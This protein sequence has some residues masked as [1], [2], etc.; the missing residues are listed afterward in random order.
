MN[1]A[2]ALADGGSLRAL[3]SSLLRDDLVVFPVR[4]HSPACALHLL[5]LIRDRRPSAVLIEGPRSFN[6][7]INLLTDE[8]ARMPLAI[9]TY[10]VERASGDADGARHAAYY[11]F[12]D[13]SPELVALR[14]AAGLGV[15]ARFIDLDYS[16]QC[17]VESGPPA[18]DAVSL[19]AE[20]H[21]ERSAYLRLLARRLGCRDHEELWEHLFECAGP[22]VPLQEHVANVAAY[23]ALARKGVPEEE[24]AADGTLAREAE[25]A[26]H[27]REALRERAA[28]TGPVLAVV[29]GFHAVV[30]PE[31]V[32][33]AVERPS[34]SRAG[35]A[36]EHSTVIRYSFD[37]LDRLNGYAA[38]MTSP[39]W[40]QRLWERLLTSERSANDLSRR[41]R[42]AAALDALFDIATLL[43]DES[44]V[45]LPM[46][47]LA[48]AFRH[49][50]GLAK[51][52]RRMA[53]AREDVVD[54][55]TS[56]FVKGDIEAEGPVVYGALHK[57]LTGTA[58]GRVPAGAPK[59]PLLRDFEYRARRQRLKVEDSTPRRVLL[60]IYR[61]PEHRVTS[62]LLHG[63]SFLGI[64]FAVRTAGPDFVRGTGLNRLQEHWEYSHTAATEASIIEASLHGVTVPLAVADRFRARLE[65]ASAGDEARNAR[66]VAALLVQGC[67]LGL[68]DHLPGVFAALRTAIAQDPDFQSVALAAG[69]LGLLWEAREPLEARDIVELPGI[70][71]ATYERSIYLGHGIAT[72]SDANAASGLMEALTRLRELLAS[73]AGAALDAES[74]WQMVQQLAGRLDEP[75]LRGTAAGLLFSA[76][77]LDAAALAGLVAGEFVGAAEPKRAVAFLRG[78]LHSAREVA[79]QQ[80]ELLQALDGLLAKWDEATFIE[81][82]PELRLA[83]ADLTPRETDRVGEAVSALHGGEVLVGLVNHD[84]GEAQLATHLEL[85]RTLLAVLEADGL[86][87]WVRQ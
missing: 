20:R 82:L 66:V 84:V 35:V 72:G 67:T 31:L 83:F 1:E 9:Y 60:D 18:E 33:Q 42:E 74:Y 12:C 52:R 21:L 28:G 46:P 19:L 75:A 68:H 45:T 39:G 32:R 29:G 59:P 65:K 63:L 54:A 64:P 26:W 22:S 23:C 17:L 56:C 25:M 43:R 41:V 51:L 44:R 30:L 38:G 40:H 11:P 15:P 69:S 76:G 8:S 48:A 71:R 53:P 57:V 2:L 5:R 80:P 24:L 87:A 36:E 73:A 7:L 14:G 47:T 37:R 70:L 34:I 79:W 62:R 78:L 55:V 16:E 81:L 85:S 4:H 27:I 3:G 10:A 86:Q 13:Y 77:R 58:A 49:S 61:R 6:R 50:L